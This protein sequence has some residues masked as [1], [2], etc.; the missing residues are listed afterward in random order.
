MNKNATSSNVSY[1]IVYGC[2]ENPPVGE[3][4]AF[5]KVGVTTDHGMNKR[6]DDYL[7]HYPDKKMSDIHTR[8]IKYDLSLFRLTKTNTFLIEKVDGKN[9]EPDEFIHKML[10]LKGYKNPDKGDAKGKHRT[11]EVFIDLPWNVVDDCITIAINNFWNWKSCKKVLSANKPSL[12]LYLWQAWNIA[13]RADVRRALP[14]EDVIAEFS[15]PRFGK[16]IRELYEFYKSDRNLLV[17]VQY[18]LSPVTS[19]FTEIES[20]AEFAEI[21]TYDATD[22]LVEISSL[23][24]DL[25]NGKKVIAISLCGEKDRDKNE[26][27]CKYLKL[28]AEASKTIIKMD[29]VDFGAATE[30]SKY[31]LEKIK[32]SLKGVKVDIF[33]GTGEDKVNFKMELDDRVKASAIRTGYIELLLIKR[34]THYLFTPEYRLSL[35]PSRNKFE[36]EFLDKIGATNYRSPEGLIKPVFFGLS[37]GDDIWRNIDKVHNEKGDYDPRLGFAYGKINKMPFKYVTVHQNIWRQFLGVDKLAGGRLDYKQF[38]AGKPLRVILTWVSAGGGMT[39]EKLHDLTDVVGNDPDIAKEWLVVPVCGKKKWG[40][41][42]KGGKTAT[43]NRNAERFANTWID[44]AK[45]EGKG[46]IFFAMILA[47]RSFSV[48]RIDAIMFYRDDLPADS[49]EQKLSRVLTPGKDFYGADK[50]C[51]YIFDLSLT[52]N[53]SVIENYIFSEINEQARNGISAKVAATKFFEVIDVFRMNQLGL[54]EKQVTFSDADFTSYAKACRTMYARTEIRD[55]VL[56]MG[57]MGAFMDFVRWA[58]TRKSLTN[59]Q[60]DVLKGFVKGAKLNDGKITKHHHPS[61]E[62]DNAKRP[63]DGF[64]QAMVLARR[65]LYESVL[66][67]AAIHCSVK[68]I[69]LSDIEKNQIKYSDILATIESNPTAFDLFKDHFK[70]DSDEQATKILGYIQRMPLD[71]KLTA[72][73]HSVI[74]ETAFGK[75]W[76]NDDLNDYLYTD[77]DDGKIHTPMS[78]VGEMMNKWIA[79]AR[80]HNDDPRTMKFLD[81]H[82][83]TGSFLRWIHQTLKDDGVSEENIQKQV[84]GIENDPVYLVLAR[85]I[86]GI[87]NIQ[88]KNLIDDEELAIFT[89]ENMKKFDVIVGNAPYQA[90]ANKERKGGSPKSIWEKFVHLSLSCLKDGGYL[91][92]IHPS[93]W[94]KPE[95]ELWNVLGSKQIIWLKIYDNAA[96]TDLFGVGTTADCYV[97]KNT[98]YISPTTVIDCDGKEHTIDFREWEWPPSAEYELIKSIIAHGDDEKCEVLYDCV[99]HNQRKDV[100]NG[101]E[102]NGAFVNPCVNHTKKNGIIEYLYSNTKERGHF[103]ITKVIVADNGHVRPINDSEGKLGMTECCFAITS[104]GKSDCEQVCNA[105]S[106]DKFAKVVWATKWGNYRTE[107]RMFRYF[108][109]DFWKDFLPANESHP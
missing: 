11:S 108:R 53:S 102:P 51:G 31:K 107:Y 43:N 69:K 16:T 56:A 1:I 97:L 15:C 88:Y 42:S 83:K 96:A 93:R 29:E 98:P 77:T 40:A 2:P 38:T 28:H 60:R 26:E 45:K 5:L 63:I 99:Y 85:H 106:S 37:V 6:F 70:F 30:K 86:S 35:D 3:T 80:G 24:P 100:V 87:D 33:S 57:D 12:H 74:L 64:T 79:V 27:F 13:K 61:D 18:N 36:I 32:N 23:P 44:R 68:N 73:L 72:N 95:D 21:E 20:W 71:D 50:K 90:P 46:V 105:L 84:M 49:A 101:E 52:P 4:S 59:Q 76:K 10:R 62:D 104:V 78:L 14:N 65:L 89:S 34:G 7:G 94:R 39:K 55:M 25:T 8:Q 67:M 103:G 47:Q 66:N 54:V 9:V 41:F 22:S 109:K 17:L 58:S 75:D 82:C 19:F 92:Y 91:C 48:S 81:P